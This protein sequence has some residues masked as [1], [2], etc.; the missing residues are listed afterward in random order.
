MSADLGLR[1]GGRQ[2]LGVASDEKH[3]FQVSF[4]FLVCQLQAD[5]VPNLGV[6]V[7]FT[8][9]FSKVPSPVSPD[10]VWRLGKSL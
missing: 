5:A 6:D 2:L 4:D 7:P 3:P 10:K 9:R 8:L 1:H